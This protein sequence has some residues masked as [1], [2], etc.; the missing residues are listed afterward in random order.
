VLAQIIQK[1]NSKYS[2]KLA[3]LNSKVVPVLS[4]GEKLTFPKLVLNNDG[5]EF[6]FKTEWVEVFPEEKSLSVRLDTNELEAILKDDS[7]FEKYFDKLFQLILPEYEKLVGSSEKLNYGEYYI[8]LS[9]KD[10]D[11]SKG[12]DSSILILSSRLVAD[13]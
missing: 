1:I 10:S 7:M 11:S 5:E 9:L 3:K 2:D 4:E 8:S 13:E 12:Y 6:E